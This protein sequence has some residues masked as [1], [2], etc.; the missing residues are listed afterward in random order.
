MNDRIMAYMLCKAKIYRYLYYQKRISRHISKHAFK[1]IL[2]YFYK[3]ISI[4]SITLFLWRM[5][6]LSTNPVH[7]K[8]VTHNVKVS[9]YCHVYNWHSVLY[10]QG[11]DM[12]QTRRG[13]KKQRPTLRFLG[14]DFSW[15]LVF[16]ASQCAS[17]KVTIS[18]PRIKWC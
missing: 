17:T 2:I 3:A 12:K 8:S 6:H 13:R 18:H 11:T 14:D 9:Y 1:M 10:K 7:I 15:C 4:I 5:Y 16:L